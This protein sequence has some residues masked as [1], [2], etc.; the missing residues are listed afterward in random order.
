MKRRGARS[1][2][3]LNHRGDCRDREATWPIS[4]PKVALKG[5]VFCS[6]GAAAGGHS[7]A[8]GEAVGQGKAGGVTRLELPGEAEDDEQRAVKPIARRGVY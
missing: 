6:A 1:M 2:D 5:R 3:F 7:G 4:R 8:A